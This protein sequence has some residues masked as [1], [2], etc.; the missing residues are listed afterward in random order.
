MAIARRRNA[1][2]NITNTITVIRRVLHS[3]PSRTRLPSIK[4]SVGKDDEAPKHCVPR[5]LLPHAVRHVHHRLI[6]SARRSALNHVIRLVKRDF[7]AAGITM[8]S[9]TTRSPPRHGCHGPYRMICFQEK[10]P[11]PETNTLLRRVAMAS[12]CSSDGCC[13]MNFTDSVSARFGNDSVTVTPSSDKRSRR[14][15]L[16]SVKRMLSPRAPKAVA[17]GGSAGPIRC[18]DECRRM[19][20]G[21]RAAKAARSAT[22]TH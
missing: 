2:A 20:S 4:Q 18:A 15:G 19:A 21:G 12:C 7:Q 11:S 17:E 3:S 8:P 6:L 9:A 1:D 16:P 13:A 22:A 5:L 10:P 14:S